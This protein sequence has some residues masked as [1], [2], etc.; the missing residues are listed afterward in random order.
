MLLLLLLHLVWANESECVVSSERIAERVSG[1][2]YS[3]TNYAKFLSALSLFNISI[4]LSNLIVISCEK[5]RISF[6]C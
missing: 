1:R 3:Y 5:S 2:F 4:V 6:S